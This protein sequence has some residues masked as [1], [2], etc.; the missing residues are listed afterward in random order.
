MKIQLEWSR[1]GCIERFFNLHIQHGGQRPLFI[2][3]LYPEAVRNLNQDDF[4]YPPR[5]AVSLERLTYTYVR[6]SSLTPASPY[7]WA[8]ENVATQVPLFELRG[9]ALA[10][11]AP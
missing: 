5:R 10:Q 6:L 8:Q 11:P 7:L 1:R 4:G 9:Q 3:P 2:S